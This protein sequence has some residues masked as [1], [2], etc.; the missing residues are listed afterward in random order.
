MQPL[1][2]TDI[3]NLLGDVDD[4]VIAEVLRLGATADE[5]AEARAWIANNE[6]LMNSGKPLA[7]GRIGRLVDMLAS[8]E[9]EEFGPEDHPT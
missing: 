3:R 6:P 5:L 9:D 1:T 7:S 2:R 4:I 8:V